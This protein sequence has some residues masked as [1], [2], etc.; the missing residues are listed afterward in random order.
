MSEKQYAFGKDVVNGCECPAVAAG[1]SPSD[2]DETAEIAEW[3]DAKVE[4]LGHD[5]RIV[6]RT[7]DYGVPI[8]SPYEPIPEAHAKEAWLAMIDEMEKRLNAIGRGEDKLKTAREIADE[9]GWL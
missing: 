1:Y 5:P 8:T 4:D 2:R 6:T 3:Y 9:L 7:T